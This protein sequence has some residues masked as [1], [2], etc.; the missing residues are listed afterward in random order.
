M[1][2]LGSIEV[3][4][5]RHCDMLAAHTGTKFTTDDFASLGKRILRAERSFNKR[6][7]FTKLD[8]RLPD[9][10]K[11]EKLPPHDAVFDVPD[12]ELDRVFNF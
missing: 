5:R 9:F 4:E 3:H 6:A 1:P 10:F 11:E 8:D 2:A 12:K 7:G